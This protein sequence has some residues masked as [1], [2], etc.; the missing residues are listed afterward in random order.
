MNASSK[1]S[2]MEKAI[3]AIER[4]RSATQPATS[5]QLRQASDRLAGQV[6]KIESMFQ[7]VTEKEGH[8]G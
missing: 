1:Q 5:T 2:L 8:Q 4:D 6:R 7:R 3:R